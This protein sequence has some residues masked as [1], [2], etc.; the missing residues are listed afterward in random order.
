MDRLLGSNSVFSSSSMIYFSVSVNSLRRSDAHMSH[1]TESSLVQDLTWRHTH[2]LNQ[3]W[4]I[5]NRV[6]INKIQQNLNG[7]RLLEKGGCYTL[8]G[9]HKKDFQV[10]SSLATV[11]NLHRSYRCP[12]FLLKLKK[13]V[14]HSP[15]NTPKCP[16][17]EK[18]NELS[19]EINLHTSCWISIVLLHI[20]Y[21]IFG[22]WAAMPHTTQT[23]R[24]SLGKSTGVPCPFKIN[25]LQFGPRGVLPSG[26]DWE[27]V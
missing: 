6:W 17:Y 22:L 24:L 12:L 14:C 5:L 26:F 11:W 13:V 25:T 18:K 15:Y 21:K 4:L 27:G 20:Y 9:S 3:W 16:E 2:Y 23:G 7:N 8:F 19:C 1:W 10:K